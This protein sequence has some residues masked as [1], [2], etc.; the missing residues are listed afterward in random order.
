MHQQLASVSG[1]VDLSPDEALNEAQEFLTQ[2]G[3]ELVERADHSLTMRRG[4]QRFFLPDSRS[5]F[6]STLEVLVHS[7]PGGGVRMKIMGDDADPIPGQEQ[8]EWSEWADSLPKKTAEK[9][10]ISGAVAQEG[11]EAKGADGERDVSDLLERFEAA[12]ERLGVRLEGLFAKMDRAN[13][14]VH[15]NGEL[16]ASDEGGELGRDLEIVAT[17]HDSSGRVVRKQSTTCRSESFFGF[18]AFSLS[19]EAGEDVPAKIRVYPKAL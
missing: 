19:M 3:Y 4:G 7:Q 10:V 17:V 16:H 8:A 2:Q 14:H 1:I 6:T 12:E 11:H 18:E 13:R 15:L 9:D 5:T